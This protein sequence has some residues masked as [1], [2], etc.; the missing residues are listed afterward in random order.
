MV[1]EYKRR[2]SWTF[3]RPYRNGAPSIYSRQAAPD[4]LLKKLFVKYEAY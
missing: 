3:F 4:D 1:F 2:T